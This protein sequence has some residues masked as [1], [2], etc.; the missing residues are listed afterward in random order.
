MR[1][2]QWNFNPSI[3]LLAFFAGSLLALVSRAQDLPDATGP[4]DPE[5]TVTLEGRQRS[6]F[7]LAVPAF[8]GIDR[9]SPE[10]ARAAKDLERGIPVAGAGG[11][12][13][14]EPHRGSAERFRDVPVLGQ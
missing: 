1:R 4:G 5:V 6:R 3:L 12:V 11:A 10:L 7:R 9:L 2:I 8:Q 13:G 14:V